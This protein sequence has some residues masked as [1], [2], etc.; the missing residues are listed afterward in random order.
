MHFQELSNLLFRLRIAIIAEMPLSAF[1]ALAS[2]LKSA[3]HAQPFSMKMRFF[4][5]RMKIHFHIKRCATDLALQKWLKGNT[6]IA[7]QF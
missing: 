2:A 3:P 5:M 4:S 6:E 7:S 1:H